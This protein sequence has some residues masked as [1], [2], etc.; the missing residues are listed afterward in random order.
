MYFFEPAFACSLQEVEEV[1]AVFG[2][3]HWPQCRK[4]RRGMR[5]ASD[6]VMLCMEPSQLRNTARSIAAAVCKNKRQQKP[7]IGLHLHP[8][9]TQ[10][11]P[12]T[13]EAEAVQP[14]RSR[15]SAGLA[16]SRALL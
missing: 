8:M 13:E 9:R 14:T 2:L 1:V 4:E 15:H 5:H 7:T 12:K 6:I 16:T 3:W 11:W 10:Q